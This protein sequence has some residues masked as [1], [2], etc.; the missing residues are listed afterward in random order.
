[1][2][3][4]MPPKGKKEKLS[5]SAV[6]PTESTVLAYLQQQNRPY[7]ATDISNNLHGAI[8]KTALQKAL[9]ALCA[10]GD[11]SSKTFGKQVVY[12]TRQDLAELPS[13]ADLDEMDETISRLKEQAQEAKERSK[14][15]TTGI[16]PAAFICCR[17]TAAAFNAV[18]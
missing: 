1:M 18:Y 7:N 11:L 9:N 6:D 15:L 13:Q 17:V 10:R 5:S 3:A 4:R 12:V 14:K 2:L 8:G 16:Q